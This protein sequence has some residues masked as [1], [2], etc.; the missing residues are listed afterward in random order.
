MPRATR[1]GNHKLRTILTFALPSLVGL[2]LFLVPVRCE[3]RLSIPIAV[4][5]KQL[6]AALGDSTDLLVTLIILTST[7][8]ALMA[9]LLAPRWIRRSPFLNAL[10]NVTPFW[11]AVRLI[12]AVLVL[13]CYWSPS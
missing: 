7:L 1:T 9:K 5:A 3:G 6:Q 2:G 10:L 13:L 4:L 8:G 12:G 11:L